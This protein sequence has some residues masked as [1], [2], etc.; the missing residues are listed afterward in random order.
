M[1]FAKRQSLFGALAEPFGREPKEVALVARY[2][3]EGGCFARLRSG[4]G[5]KWQTGPVDAAFL[6]LALAA[7]PTA[8]DAAEVA[9][10][11]GLLQTEAG[12]TLAHYLGAML[13]DGVRQFDLNLGLEAPWADLVDRKT[14]EALSFNPVPDSQGRVAW[15]RHHAA[16]LRTDG[17]LFTRTGHVPADL[18]GD[19]GALF[20]APNEIVGEILNINPQGISL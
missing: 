7:S 18:I 19:I 9:R 14:G 1:K 6:I 4:Q 17:V 20:K 10:H 3:R 8:S 15:L 13:I 11:Y 12:D 2:L 5:E 16:T